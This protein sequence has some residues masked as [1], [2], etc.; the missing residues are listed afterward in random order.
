MD[1]YARSKESHIALD[2]LVAGL[3]WRHGNAG[4]PDAAELVQSRP[5]GSLVAAAPGRPLLPAHQLRGDGHTGF[6]AQVLGLLRLPKIDRRFARFL[7]NGHLAWRVHL[8]L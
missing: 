8:L 7:G 3:R 2:R 5:L 1:K 4:V 6:G